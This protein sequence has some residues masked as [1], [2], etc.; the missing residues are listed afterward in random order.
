MKKIFV[1]IS[2]ILITTLF[3]IIYNY[4]KNKVVI[5]N[6]LYELID[7]TKIEV[8]SEIKLS[9]LIKTI[10]G[11]INE[12]FIIDTDSLGVKEITFLYKDS[13]KRN[14]KGVFEIEVIDTTEPFIYSSGVLTVNAGFDGNLVEKIISI[15]NYDRTPKREII[16]EYDINKPGS[17]SLKYKVT[18]QSLNSEEIDLILIVRDISKNNNTNNKNNT[19]SYTKFIDI[20]SIHKNNNTKIG[21]DVSKWQGEIDYNK[22]KSSGV[23]FVI[24]RIG[25][26]LGFGADRIVDPYFEDNY[27]KASDAGLLVGVYFYSYATNKKEALEDSNFVLETLNHRKLD[28]PV[29]YDWESF[30]YINTLNMSLHDLNESANTFL[31]NIE[32]NGYKGILYGSKNYLNY[33]WTT[34]YPIWLAHYTSKTDYD[35]E[36]M[37]WQL[38]EDG[39]VS[40]INGNVDI[41]ILYE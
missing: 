19:I 22:L 27:K 4:E 16:G 1:F 8:Y 14:K 38:C 40:G 13:K 18:D 26:G 32:S 17:Y 7:N 12:D 3:L 39:R 20:V 31:N 34:A 37:L 24:M 41:D 28:L 6:T 33:F 15:D 36:Y 29:A 9:D 35:K 2:I 25:T 30:S 23:E 5:D 11:T 21:I 10:D